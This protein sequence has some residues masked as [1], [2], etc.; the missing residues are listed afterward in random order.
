MRKQEK[1]IMIN[2]YKEQFAR[3]MVNESD[4]EK[5]QLD[6]QKT[7]MKLFFTDKEINAIENSVRITNE[8]LKE[9]YLNIESWL[10]QIEKEQ[11][12]KEFL[13]SWDKEGIKKV[14]RNYNWL[15]EDYKG[16]KL[17]IEMIEKSLQKAA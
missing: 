16:L 15:F 9:Q 11:G 13:F 1:E 14:N 6:G 17:S 4:F 7:M 2:T 12:I 10:H 8:Y 5:L 3:Y